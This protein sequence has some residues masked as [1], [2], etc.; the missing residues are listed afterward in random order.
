[1]VQNLNMVFV[2]NLNFYKTFP[3]GK[4]SGVYYPYL[5]YRSRYY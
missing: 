3:L 4:P 2:L 5:L 1:M